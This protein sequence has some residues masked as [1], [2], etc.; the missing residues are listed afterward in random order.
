MGLKRET[1]KQ[2][3]SFYLICLSQVD[4]VASVTL[5]TIGDKFLG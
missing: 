5:L 1:F 2:N 3:N 4:K